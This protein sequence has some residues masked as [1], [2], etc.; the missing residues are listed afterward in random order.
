MQKALY[1]RY[2]LCF[3]MKCSSLVLILCISV[4]GMLSAADVKSQDLDNVPVTIDLDNASLQEGF[5]ALQ[6]ASGVLVSFSDRLVATEKKKITLHKTGVSAREVLVMMLKGTHLTYRRV[7]NY[8]VIDQA[9][10][11]VVP[12]TIAGK[13][14]DDKTGEVLI[15]STVSVKNHTAHSIADIDGRFILRLEAGVYDIE[16]RSMGY[17]TKVVQQVTVLEGKL[18]AL[19]VSLQQDAAQL[20]EVVVTAGNERSSVEALYTRQKN[21]AGITDGISADQ[22]SRTP[23]K[24]IAETLKRISGLSS[25]DNKYVVVR[26]LSERYNQAMMNGQMMPSTELNRKNF[27]YDIIPTSLVDNVIVI[28]GLTPD[29]NA[30]FGGGL[31]QINTRDIPAE[32]FLSA[33]IGVTGNDQTTGKVFR[34]PRIDN[35]VYLGGIPDDRKLFGRIDW[36]SRNEILNS[37]Y[38]DGSGYEDRNLK[39][40]SSFANNWGL[41]VYKPAPTYNGQL[42][43]G[44][45]IPV[46]DD[47]TIGIIA[48]GSYRNTWQTQPIRM[49]R[50]GYMPADGDPE[51]YGFAGTRYGFVT[52]LG[53]LAG[54]G[55]RTGHHKVSLQS[56][57]LRTFDHQYVI[58]T[59]NNNF[60]NPGV[61][62]YDLLTAT[63]L[64]QTQARSEHALSRKGAKL[65]LALSYTL[66]D[67]QKPDNH[68]T[69]STFVNEG[70][71]NPDNPYADFSVISHYSP[72]VSA[73]AGRWWSRAL[74]KN[75]GWNADFSQPFQVKAGKLA[76]SNVVKTG[77]AGWNKD[78]LFWVLITGS[79]FFNTADPE[80]ISDAFDPADGGTI[81][82]PRFGDDFHKTASLHAGYAMLDSKI[83]NNLRLVWGGRAE[84]YNMNGAN[85][86]LDA[87]VKDQKT[88]NGDLT[89]Y[90]DLYN[91]EPD[92][93]FF[94]SANLTYS[95][96]PK[97]NLRLSYARSIIRPDL[98]E[99]AYFREYDFE[100]GGSYWSQSPITSTKLKHL[101]F[102]YEWY[103]SAGEVF[104]VS[105]FYKKLLYPMEIFAKENR[106]FELR[107][108]KDAVN[109]GFEMELRKSLAFTHVPVLQNLTISGNF[110]RLF[111]S[112]RTMD[113]DYEGQ[114]TS[115]P[116]KLF[117]IEKI[118]PKEER[119]QSGASNFLYNASLYYDARLL[120]GSLSYNQIS[121]RFYRVGTSD[122][123]SLYEQPLKSLDAQ[124]AFRVLKE[125]GTIKINASNLLDSKYIIY[126]NRYEGN[127]VVP[128]GNRQPTTKELLYDKGKDLIDYE[129][130]PGRTYSI[131]FSYNF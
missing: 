56:M 55:Y 44:R 21:A 75:L 35:R 54:I 84:Y 63:S 123:G 38:F 95:L 119:P 7:D 43:A 83:G 88:K 25:L 76:I 106:L 81:Y 86:I 97:M 128:P 124:L 1:L 46:K 82:S 101:D 66:L 57:F 13:I 65:N 122:V 39:D 78:R 79:T 91:R 131:T 108:D 4:A 92:W 125:K 19:D 3:I 30:E 32:N 49:S 60:A 64:W 62:M 33:S 102:R 53:G 8:V 96:T 130:A 85:A 98:R 5:L 58:G 126:L 12:G 17:R 114:D 73:G 2:S 9:P 48:S 100:L 28:K 116:N 90:S 77:Y 112:V 113:I 70:D 52:N 45:V 93:N 67:R 87:F 72:V 80:P 118:G 117:V 18:T 59:G 42:S 121:N 34:S 115:N 61:S 50:D 127:Q 120:S 47:K 16:F 23:D 29:Q 40:A 15:G 31:V 104:S 71:D 41:H 103:P 129:A 6:H 89:D 99:I 10:P 37:G 20:G 14:V 27:S 22:I 111:A 109:K 107:N 36:R 105:L 110:T 94:P 74:E 26:G 68:Q 24:N 51:K 69:T 11:V